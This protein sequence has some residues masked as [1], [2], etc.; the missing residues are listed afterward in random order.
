MPSLQVMTFFLVCVSGSEQ[1]WQQVKTVSDR[2]FQN[3][4]VT[5]VQSRNAVI[6]YIFPVK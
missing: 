1:N 4:F 5:C 2:K 3:S 6:L